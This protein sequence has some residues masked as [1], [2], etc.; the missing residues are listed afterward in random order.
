MP[1]EKEVSHRGMGGVLSLNLNLRWPSK[2]SAP[3]LSGPPP[4]AINF[5]SWYSVFS[6]TKHIHKAFT[7]LKPFS[8]K[9]ASTFLC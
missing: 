7:L 3:S 4:K 2:L 8:I 9:A 1:L 5:L 6:G